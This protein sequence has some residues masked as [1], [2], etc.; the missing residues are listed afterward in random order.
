MAL[1]STI[2]DLHRRKGRDR[3]GLALAEGVRLVEEM[4]VAD[5]VCKGAVM[6]PVLLSTP[7][8]LALRSALVEH[9]VAVTDVSDDEL[10][11]L[12]ATEH[13]QGVVAVYTPR[14]WTLADIIAAP[15]RPIIVLDGVQD[16][17]NVGTIART[18]LAF[19]AAGLIALPGTVDLANPKVVRAAMGALFRL[20]SLHC[21]VT[22][23]VTWLGSTHVAL[24]ATA[25]DGETLADA[26]R[27]PI[28]IALGNEGA[29]LSCE[30]LAQASRR[31]SIPIDPAAESLNVAAA[32]AILLYQ[33]TRCTA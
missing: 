31:V 22:P 4:L 6:A 13:P 3:R 30:L 17:G 16:P 19:G 5:A 7:R 26:P 23:F 29:G 24:W 27:E 20:P 8:G 14:E 21:E 11:E 32:A 10:L 15:G 1:L 9:G 12:A 33:V 18:A 25:V 2:R 28:A